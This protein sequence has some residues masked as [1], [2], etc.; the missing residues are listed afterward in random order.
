M[1]TKTVNYTSEQ[2]ANML[3]V[4]T[5]NPTQDTVNTLAVSMGKTARS[6]IAKLS[7]MGVYKAKEYVRKDN[8]SV[9][10]KDTTATA[11]GTILGLSEADTDSLAKANRK[12]LQAVFAALANSKP[13]D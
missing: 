5:A 4:Y 11:I 8:T 9:E 12:A 3:A 13:L 10:K 6:V 7:R 1:A 2:E